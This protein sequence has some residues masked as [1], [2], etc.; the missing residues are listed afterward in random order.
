MTSPRD[1]IKGTLTL[2][3][4][5]DPVENIDPDEITDLF[6]RLNRM[7]SAWSNDG[8]LI[9][10][11]TQITHTLTVNDGDYTIG[12]GA[13]INTTRPMKIKT[14]FIRNSNHDYPVEIVDEYKFN[15][16]HNKAVQSTYPEYLYYRTGFPTGTVNLWP[17]PSQ[18]NTL[19]M[20]VTVPLTAFS[21]LS[22]T[23]SLPPGYE[24]AIEYN[25]LKRIAGSY[26][27]VMTPEQREIADDSLADIRRVNMSNNKFESEPC[28]PFQGGGYFDIDT[29]GY[30]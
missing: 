18:A 22:E 16:V 21:T 11:D 1:L 12:S 4:I 8:A 24:E 27:V 20:D 3:G 23:I 15:R 26:G 5:L 19:Y 10:A 28:T 2:G 14:A 17:K 6:S 29:G 30:H 13:D 9:Y 7:I 25:F